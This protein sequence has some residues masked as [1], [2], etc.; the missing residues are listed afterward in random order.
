MR[1]RNLAHDAEGSTFRWN[2]FPGLG[3]RVWVGLG[4]GFSVRFSLGSYTRVWD[5]A[6]LKNLNLTWSAQ[7]FPS[8]CPRTGNF[9]VFKPDPKPKALNTSTS[10]TL[11]SLLSDIP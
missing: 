8:I 10:H 3:V 9:R 11:K 7:G 6:T 4:V 2:R 5:T 1:F